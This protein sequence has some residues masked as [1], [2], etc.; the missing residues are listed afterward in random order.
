M[1]INDLVGVKSKSVMNS[2]IKMMIKSHLLPITIEN[3]I[4]KYS[5]WSK[6]TLIHLLLFCVPQFV[7]AILYWSA[8][9]QSGTLSNFMNNSTFAEK[10]SSFGTCLIFLQ[11]YLILP[12]AKQLNSFPSHLVTMDQ[13]KF[14]KYGTWNILAFIMMSTGCVSFNV[15]LLGEHGTGSDDEAYVIAFVSNLFMVLTQS[16]YWCLFSIVIQVWLENIIKVHSKNVIKDSR[17]FALN[18]KMFT[19]ALENYFFYSFAI[20]QIFSITTLFLA[21]SKLILEVTFIN[22]KSFNS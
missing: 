14:P 1:S 7:V 20:F 2:V 8:L 15:T 9:Y 4:Y 18:Y 16:L 17:I 21:C 22:S 19:T 3:N 11:V 5:F 13:M 12:L 10:F 6:P